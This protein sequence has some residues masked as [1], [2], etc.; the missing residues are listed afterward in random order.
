MYVCTCV[1]SL[2]WPMRSKFGSACALYVQALPRG[3][4]F[5]HI[6]FPLCRRISI[7]K[8][9][10]LSGSCILCPF[11]AFLYRRCPRLDVSRSSVARN[12]FHRIC[13]FLKEKKRDGKGTIES[14]FRRNLHAI[15]IATFALEKYS[16]RVS[17]DSSRRR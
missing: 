13:I 17:A 11:L 14:H 9:V 15:T 16:T 7:V 2:V 8:N 6:V 12:V 1:C 5:T 3:I 4:V 10:K